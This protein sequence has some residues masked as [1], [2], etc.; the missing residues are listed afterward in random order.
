MNTAKFEIYQHQATS[1]LTFALPMKPTRDLRFNLTNS[2]II[3]GLETRCPTKANKV[4]RVVL[5]N[6]TS[7][8][9]TQIANMFPID[10]TTNTLSLTNYSR[11][12]QNILNGTQVY[13]QSRSESAISPESLFMQIIINKYTCTTQDI[14]NVSEPAEFVVER[15]NLAGASGLTFDMASGF[16]DKSG[17]AACGLTNFQL[18][19]AV[20][21]GT[22]MGI[23]MNDFI[24][25]TDR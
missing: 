1:G 13:V 12:D 24:Q 15:P 20:I 14:L 2:A 6:G 11:I 3:N 23:R 19:K 9:S 7:L 8:D 21:N 16:F 17:I 4:T 10:T 25:F 5:G 22:D 18:K